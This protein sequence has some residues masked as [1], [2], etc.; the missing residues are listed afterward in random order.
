MLHQKVHGFTTSD[1]S[2]KSE[3]D[4]FPAP[5]VGRAFSKT[6]NIPSRGGPVTL[7]SVWFQL[8]GAC[9]IKEFFQHLPWAQIE[10]IA[11]QLLVEVGS[12]LV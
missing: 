6:Q 12:H 4:V 2:A 9:K 8:D 11:I 10:K 1:C 3:N 7:G 5:P